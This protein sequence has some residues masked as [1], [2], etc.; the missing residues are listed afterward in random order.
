MEWFDLQDQEYKEQTLPTACKLRISIEAGSTFGWDRYVG[1]TGI[2]IGID[3]FGS[4]GDGELVMSKLGISLEN[5]T[6]KANQLLKHNNKLI[7][8]K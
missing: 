1:P 6:D 4:S 7:T 8:E 2:K 3:E 5:L